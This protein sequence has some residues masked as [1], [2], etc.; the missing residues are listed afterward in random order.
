M[1]VG[2]MTTN[3]TV[4]NPANIRKYP[5]GYKYNPKAQTQ[6]TKSS[7]IILQEFSLYVYISKT[8]PNLKTIL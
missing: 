6:I 1:I 8:I 4:D 5:Y 7:P 2:T 3:C